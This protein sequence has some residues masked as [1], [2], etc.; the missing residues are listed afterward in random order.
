MIH[1]AGMFLRRALRRKT[2]IVP[3]DLLDLPVPLGR[4]DRRDHRDKQGEMGATG[5][6]AHRGRQGKPDHKGR[7]D[8]KG[9]K[10]P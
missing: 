5:R 2:A 6:P 10:A 4:P 1:N 8:R 7:R 3:Q 9:H